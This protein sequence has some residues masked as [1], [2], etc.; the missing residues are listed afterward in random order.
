MF[1]VGSC[2]EHAS[3]PYT[4]NPCKRGLLARPARFG[5]GI[6]PDYQIRDEKDSFT[7]FNLQLKEFVL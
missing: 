3:C 7:S 1:P 2:P 5:G 4:T 6:G